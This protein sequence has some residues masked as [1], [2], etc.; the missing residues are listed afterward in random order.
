MN[1]ISP[2][3]GRMTLDEVFDD[4]IKYVEKA[5]NFRYKIIIGTDSHNKDDICFV[6]AIIVH[7]VGKGAKYYYKRF[8]QRKI[9]NLRQ[10]IFTETSL[11]LEV[12]DKIKKKL[13]QTKYKN[14]DLEVHVDIGQKG[15]TKEL[16]KEVV[17][18]VMGSGYRVKIKP[19]ACGA[20]KV[21][22][23]YTK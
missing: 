5:P 20:T 1:F 22:D 2:T 4:I 12:V 13:E 11:S 21:A 7:R 18:W 8:Y 23:K 17:G 15:D 6:T 9:K 10:K 3:K 14:M 19:N 16:I